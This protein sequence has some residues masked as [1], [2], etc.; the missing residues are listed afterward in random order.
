MCNM[1]VQVIYASEHRH[2]QSSTHIHTTHNTVRTNGT[3]MKLYSP[4]PTRIATVY[5]LPLGPNSTAPCTYFP[6]GTI[7]TKLSH[8]APPSAGLGTT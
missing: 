4:P 6:G 5:S 2:P 8:A 3:T 1:H 7:Y